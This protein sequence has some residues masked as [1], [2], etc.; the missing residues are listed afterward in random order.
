MEHSPKRARTDRGQDRLGS[1]VGIA[2]EDPASMLPEAKGI[3]AEANA[4]TWRADLRNETLRNHV[5]RSSSLPN[6]RNGL[7]LTG[8]L[9]IEMAPESF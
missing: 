6:E 5:P 8:R 2:R 7:G 1:E 4:R 3:A 9:P